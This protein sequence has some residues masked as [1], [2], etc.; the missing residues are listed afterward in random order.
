MP[1]SIWNKEDYLKK[2]K[3]YAKQNSTKVQAYSGTYT[4]TEQKTYRSK[5]TKKIIKKPITI[6]APCFF[7]KK[8][9]KKNARNMKFRNL[10]VVVKNT[11]TGAKHEYSLPFLLGKDKICDV[12]EKEITIHATKYWVNSFNELKTKLIQGLP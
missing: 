9:Y 5:S 6:K 7:I 8:F 4:K 2:S 10:I 11:K 12:F 3:K 1:K